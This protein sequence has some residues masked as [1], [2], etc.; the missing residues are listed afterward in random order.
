[1][2]PGSKG[3]ARKK[4]QREKNLARRSPHASAEWGGPSGIAK[5]GTGNSEFTIFLFR[6]PHSA[7]RF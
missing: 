5:F 7:F 1:L 6:T 3:A 4:H 2:R